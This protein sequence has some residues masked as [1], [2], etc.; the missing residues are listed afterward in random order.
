[1][2]TIKY[3]D[4]D[5]LYLEEIN[6]FVNESMH[7]FI[8]KPYKIRKDVADIEKHYIKNGG[9]FWLAVDT[10]SNKIIGTIG[11]VKRENIG[12]VKRFYVQEEYQN[13]KIGT[14]L[15]QVLEKYCKKANIQIL[16]LACGNILEKAHRFYL[17][18]G[19]KQID[20]LEIDM[21][22]GEQDDFFKK[23]L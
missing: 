4:Y 14:N 18:N 15:Y 23:V 20:K 8:N 7:K 19:Y 9:N 22:V 13:K 11:L 3:L 12:I 21:H 17:N 6:D 2:E 5:N 16:Y 10:K 1:M